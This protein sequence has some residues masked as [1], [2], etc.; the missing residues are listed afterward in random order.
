MS[1]DRIH[2]K[3]EKVI[4]DLSM[5]PI[6]CTG[7]ISTFSPYTDYPISLSEF[8]DLITLVAESHRNFDHHSY[9]LLHQLYSSLLVIAVIFV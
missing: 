6:K 1:N 8:D 3:L 9:Q 2:H 7:D 4:C 5:M